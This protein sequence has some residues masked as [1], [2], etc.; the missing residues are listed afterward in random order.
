MKMVV[1]CVVAPCSV[2][3][4]R[5][6]RGACCHHHKDDSSASLNGLITQNA[7][8]FILKVGILFNFETVYQDRHDSTVPEEDQLI[9]R[10]RYRAKFE[11]D[12][13]KYDPLKLVLLF[14]MMIF[15]VTKQANGL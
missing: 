15:L 4:Y 9:D 11:S 13:V 5:R 14:I 8:I 10:E 7:A 12:L 3:D 1:F 2:V 6:L